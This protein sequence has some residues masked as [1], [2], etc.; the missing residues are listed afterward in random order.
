MPPARGAAPATPGDPA[1]VQADPAADPAADRKADPGF[2]HTS[3][4]SEEPDAA[5]PSLRRIE[6]PGA[7]RS[8]GEHC[9]SQIGRYLLG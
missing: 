5:R 6:L 4:T 2:L 7:L 8:G 1:T 3:L 9:A